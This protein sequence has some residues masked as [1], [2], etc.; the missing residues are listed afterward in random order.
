LI[1]WK[2]DPP[3]PTSGTKKKFSL[4]PEWKIKINPPDGDDDISGVG[5][6]VALASTS[7]LPPNIHIKL[8]SDTKGGWLDGWKKKVLFFGTVS[9]SLLW[10]H[11]RAIPIGGWTSTT[12]THKNGKWWTI[13]L[14]TRHLGSPSVSHRVPLEL[15]PVALFTTSKL[16]NKKKKDSCAYQNFKK[17]LIFFQ[18][19]KN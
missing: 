9:L 18:E 13:R 12:S 14:A 5:L 15:L 6:A 2:Y 4:R 1:I 8:L 10:T 19:N 17:F 11:T 16:N 3:P 7:A